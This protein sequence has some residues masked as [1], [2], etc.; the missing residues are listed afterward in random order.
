MNHQRQTRLYR[1]T[2]LLLKSQQLF[3][4]KL[5]TPIEVKSNLANS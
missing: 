4:L 2:Y 3:L 1:P 5:A